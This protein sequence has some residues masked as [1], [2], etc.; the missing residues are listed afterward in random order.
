MEH[1]LESMALDAQSEA[2]CIQEILRSNR[3]YQ[4][5][6]KYRFLMDKIVLLINDKATTNKKIMLDI[7]FN[8]WFKTMKSKIDLSK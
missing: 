5:T 7:D 2:Q 3:I 1:E 6:K 8:K 4:G